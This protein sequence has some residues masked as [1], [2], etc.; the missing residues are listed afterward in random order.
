[1]I[2]YLVIPFGRSPSGRPFALNSSYI[3]V[4]FEPPFTKVQNHERV[5]IRRRKEIETSLPITIAIREREKGKTEDFGIW[6]DGNSL[7][8]LSLFT[9]KG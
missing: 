6:R 1:L 2:S 9:P 7:L 5:T 4:E 3:V 8:S